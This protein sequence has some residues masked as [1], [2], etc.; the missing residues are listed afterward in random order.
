MLPATDNRSRC[1]RQRIWAAI[2]F[3][4]I[5]I[6][7]ASGQDVIASS[8]T[9]SGVIR[10][11]DR[12]GGELTDRSDVVVFI[13]GLPDSTR[14]RDFPK[15]PQV[16]HRDRQ[17]SP[18][19]LPLV[20]GTT[21]DFFNDDNIFHNVFSLSRPKSFDLGIYPE[22]TSKLVTFSEPGLVKLH[23]NIHPKMTST[24]LVLN[25]G[26][27]ATTGMDGHFQIDGVPDGRLTLRVW[28]EFSEEQ[29]R[30]VTLSGGGR[31]EES[32]D[33]YETKRFVQ[34]KNKFGKRYPEKY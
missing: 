26:L 29:S 33:V 31:V 14:D 8:N 22:G 10:V 16:S 19:V 23:C 12:N 2:V 28:S 18:R 9:V 4:A 32:F 21:V 15:P 13:D 27:F 30:T 11:F 1:G 25:N 5:A 34:H 6:S 7:D 3:A 17:F 24:I 20:R